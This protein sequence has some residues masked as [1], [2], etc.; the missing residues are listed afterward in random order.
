MV[1]DSIIHALDYLKENR[2]IDYQH[3]MLLEPTA[4]L[5]TKEHI[6]DAYELL[7]S[8]KCKAVVSMVAR[9]NDLAYRFLHKKGG[10]EPVLRTHDSKLVD[11]KNQQMMG[12]VLRPNAAIYLSE[13]ET[14]RKRR[15]FY[16]G[17]SFAFEMPP[18]TGFD[19]DDP[20]EFELVEWLYNHMGVM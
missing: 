4:P 3:L 16:H 20:Y 10:L 1:I 12:S 7:V 9:P 19:I 13:V 2:G 15:S 8:S 11:H 6:R 5:R 18:W 17:D 14:L